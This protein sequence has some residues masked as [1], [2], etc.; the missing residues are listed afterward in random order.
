MKSKKIGTIVRAAGIAISVAG[1]AAMAGDLVRSDPMPRATTA[2][3]GGG[4]VALLLTFLWSALASRAV[5]RRP[6]T[7]RRLLASPRVP[8]PELMVFG[9]VA[10]ALTSVLL[11]R[12]LADWPLNSVT[13]GVFRRPLFVFGVCTAAAGSLVVV[14]GSLRGR[15]RAV[16]R[17]R[18]LLT[19]GALLLSFGLAEVGLR[20]LSATRIPQVY[21]PGMH[22]RTAPSPEVLPGVE[23]I[24]TFTTNQLG[25][26]GDELPADDRYRILAIGGSTTIS[27]Y[28]DDS[29][30]WPYALQTM[31]NGSPAGGQR[32]WVGNAGRSGQRL[33][34]HLQVFEGLVP[35]LGVD[36][37]I[38][39]AGVNDL[40][41]FL[42][43]PES[44]TEKAD[45][46]GRLA[47]PV[48]WTFSRPPLVDPAIPRAFPQNLALWNLAHR[49]F[50]GL[51][52]GGVQTEDST[53]SNYVTRRKIYRAAPRVIDGLPE[54]DVGLWRYRTELE[55][56]VNL[57][58]RRNVRLILATQPV[59]WSDSLS[60]RAESLLWMGL[61]GNYDGVKGRYTPDALARGMTA[62]NDVVRAVCQRTR[63]ECVDLAARMTGQERYYFDDVHFSEAGS[64]TVARILAEHLRDSPTALAPGT[65]PE[66]RD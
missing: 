3:L 66:P 12:V 51:T 34:E 7:L 20:A 63:T 45:D 47:F 21:P 44:F 29:E 62:Y 61:Y 55:T 49:A 13:L 33:T 27:M 15:R 31:L 59:I 4:A 50:T 48:A 52:E 18:V 41:Q 30:A 6:R 53:A 65:L 8:L 39:L 38:V 2:F 17:E 35:R 14:L 28:L 26:R 36:A 10:V 54:L 46:P 19:S 56:L 5:D 9:A 32:V 60:G 40:L 22:F 57:A 37:V 42:R 16:L 58:R 1:Y 25:L 24:A 23:G 43:D 64:R 11:W